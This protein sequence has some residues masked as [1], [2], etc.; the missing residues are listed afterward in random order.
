MKRRQFIK[1]IAYGGIATTS[2]IAFAKVAE[3]YNYNYLLSHDAKS[4]FVFKNFIA[5]NVAQDV[6]K[7][8]PPE[9]DKQV[10]EVVSSLKKEF[11]ERNFTENQTLFSNRLGDPNAPL[12]GQQK[13]EKLGPNP[14]FGTVQLLR[15]V[16]SS[17]AF[18]GS[19]TAGIQT[20]MKI[21]AKDANINAIELDG[22]FIPVRESFADWGTW[23][24]DVNPNTG[25]LESLLSHSSYETKL[26]E[27][28][29][30]Y[31]VVKPGPGGFGEIMMQVDA[32]RRKRTFKIRV[33]FK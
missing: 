30:T 24:G 11:N 1:Q 3:A 14:G 13:T 22:L 16:S 9:T 5:L 2:T 25:E 6:R 17:I 32:L 12:W 23:D 4:D 7:T 19:T 31:K 29:R 26:G 21:L 27:V 10:I 28:F 8:L 20:G 18:T 15:N 33:D